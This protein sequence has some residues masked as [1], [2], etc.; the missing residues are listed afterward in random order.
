[1][2]YLI[3]TASIHTKFGV[4]NDRKERYLEC[5]ATTLNLVKDD[6]DIKVIVVENNGARATYLDDLCHVDYTD[7][8]AL[9]FPHKATNELLDVQEIMRRY[10]IQDDVLRDEFHS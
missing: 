4:Q 5:L 9:H 7:N 1:M 2:I 6:P 3:V 10:D 8:N